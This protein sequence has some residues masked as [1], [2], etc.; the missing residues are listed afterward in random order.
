MKKYEVRHHNKAVS[1][2]ER[3]VG[4][5]DINT[6]DPLAGVFGVSILE[7]VKADNLPKIRS[8]TKMH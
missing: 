7:L 8:R 3:G 2:W 4:F 5:L 6:I 1:R